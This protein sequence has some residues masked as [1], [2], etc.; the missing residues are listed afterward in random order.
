MIFSFVVLGRLHLPP[1]DLGE[2]RELSAFS[3]DNK[4][5]F[6]ARIPTFLPAAGGRMCIRTGLF[7]RPMGLLIE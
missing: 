5:T 3:A 6:L 2:P 4:T 1:K 7:T